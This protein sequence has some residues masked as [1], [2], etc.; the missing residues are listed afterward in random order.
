MKILFLDIDG[1]LNCKLS[2]RI[3]PVMVMRLNE[4]LK[5]TGAKVVISSSWRMVHTVA[6]IQK[7][8]EAQGFVGDIIG[9]TPTPPDDGRLILFSQTRGHEIESWLDLNRHLEVQRFIALDDMGPQQFPQMR[10]HLVQTNGSLGLQETDVERAF[11]KL[12]E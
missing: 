5:L 6:E 1:V 11:L 7:L 3:D 12:R 9:M 4:I 8:L 2:D 10:K